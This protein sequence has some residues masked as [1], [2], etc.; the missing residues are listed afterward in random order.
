MAADRAF[1]VEKKQLADE[2]AQRLALVGRAGV[3][4]RAVRKKNAFV[5]DADGAGVEAANMGADAVE[6]AHGEDDTLTGDVEV[7]PTSSGETAAMFRLQVIGCEA[8][9]AAGSGAMYYNQVD[10]ADAVQT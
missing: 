9:V 2:E 7:V 5:G 8:A 6:R 1:G 10:T 3:G 4:R